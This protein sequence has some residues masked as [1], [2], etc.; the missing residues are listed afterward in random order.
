MSEI[1]FGL[2]IHYSTVAKYHQRGLKA[3]K[4]YLD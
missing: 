2:G 3:L 1:A 4:K